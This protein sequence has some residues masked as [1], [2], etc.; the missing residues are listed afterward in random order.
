VPQH[1]SGVVVVLPRLTND[2]A[3]C[4]RDAA[5][6]VA[7]EGGA[8]SHG[9]NLLREFGVPAVISTGRATERLRDGMTVTVDGFRGNVYAGDLSVGPQT[10]ADV[11]R[12]LMKVFASVLV[13]EKAEV[14]AILAD[15]V[16][17][18]RNDYFLL[19]SGVHPLETIRCGQA[20]ELE[21]T[22]FR[23]ICRTAETF[24]GKPLWYKTMDAPTDE[25]RRLAGG[26]HEPLE[27][28]PLLGWRGIGRELLE[29]EM[30]AVELR[31]VARAVAEGHEHL[32]IK[33][34]F[35]RFV[36]EFEQA[37]AAAV[38]V[39]LRPGENVALGIS[40]E[41]PAVALGLSGF[42]E[43]GAA[44]V[45]VGVSDLTMCTLAVDRE[46]HRVA[47][48]FHPAAPAVVG[49]LEHIARTSRGAGVF[50]CATG[51][52]ARDDALLPHLI[53]MRFDAVGVSLAY[54]AEVKERIH[55]I[56][57]ASE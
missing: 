6:V 22:L 27:R 11:P 53:R 18:L 50:A 23:G 44:F 21:E 39:G 35:I 5:G 20:D 9:A 10:L 24:A 46:S 17:S 54:F 33:L 40:V 12:T 49:L 37:R 52:S 2:L 7:D 26:E 8:T 32:G 19:K 15:G 36:S 1:A 16:S 14:V 3:V 30:L 25:F 42:L 45:S 56:E 28:N 34:P 43:A 48:H 47:G 31:A 51:E 29:P 38:R 13:P 55:R 57:R 41:T 4:L